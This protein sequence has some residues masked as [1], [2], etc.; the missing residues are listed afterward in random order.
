MAVLSKTLIKRDVVHDFGCKIDD[1]RENNEKEIL[2]SQAAKAAFLQAQKAVEAICA[3]VEQDFDSG[4]LEAVLKDSSALKLLEYIKRQIMRGG[5]ACDNL[6]TAAQLQLF[7]A[8]GALAA[9]TQILDMAKK[10]HDR[11]VEVLEG[12]RRAIEAGEADEDPDT[13][14]Y[15]VRPVG[16]GVSAAEDLANRRAEAKAAK[17]SKLEASSK[18][19]KPKKGVKKP[20]TGKAK[21]PAKDTK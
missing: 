1:I 14:D 20:T 3:V 7:R 6:A 18:E 21:K 15:S 10:E 9:T 4:A 11:A 5:G 13:G 8:E 17:A 2:V 19:D 16:G 12:I